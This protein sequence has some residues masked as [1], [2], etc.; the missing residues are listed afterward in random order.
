[1]NSELKGIIESD[2]YRYYGESKRPFL[3]KKRHEILNYTTLYRKARYYKDKNK[4]KFLLY[5]LKMRIKERKTNMCLP[6]EAE[7]GNGLQIAHKGN[8]VL[9]HLV[10]IGKNCYISSSVTIGLQSRGKKAGVPTLGDC[11]WLGANTV[12]VG[13]V[14]IGNN[15]LIA[16]NTYVNFDV[17]DNSIVIGSPGKIIP[18]KNATEGYQLNTV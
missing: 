5:K 10:K 9:Y 2:C 6:I 17:P 13:N 12:I 11:V 18:R 15:V 16:P 1:M 8:I 3:Y 4:L 7:I 14:K